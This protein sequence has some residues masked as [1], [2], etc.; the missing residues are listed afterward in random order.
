MPDFRFYLERG[1]RRTRELRVDLPDATVVSLVAKT[2]AHHYAASE[3]G[4]GRLHLAQDIT[5][6]DCND[7]EVGRYP[8]ASFLCIEEA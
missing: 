6:L 1:N 5:V 2:V 8:L 4:T 7:S 3:I